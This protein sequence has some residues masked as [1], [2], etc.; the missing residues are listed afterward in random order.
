MSA[1]TDAPNATDPARAEPRARR[2]LARAAAG[3]AALLA[4]AYL[5]IAFYAAH[6]LTSPR[7]RDG[8][9]DARAIDPAA[10]DW[11][12]TAEDGLTLRGW[13][14]PTPAH[15]RLAIFVHGLWDRWD[16]IAPQA[17]DLHRRGFDVLA[18]DLRGHGRSDRDRLSMG[19]RERRDVR[20]AL[21]WAKEEGFTPDR[22]GWVGYSLGGAIVVMEAA[23]NPEIRVG[24]VDSPFGDLPEVLDAQLARHSGLPGFFNPAILLAARVAFDVPVGDLVPIRAAARWGDRPLLVI[25]GTADHLVPPDQSRRLAGAAGPSAEL[26]IVPGVRHIEAHKADPSG[27]TD[28]LAAFLDAHLAP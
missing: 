18:F 28:R 11:T 7:H 13:Y 9:A 21:R 1:S 24:V 16:V 25:H 14:F 4:T 19:H 10:V 5:G 22:I 12:A 27:Y 26:V 6:K 17:A 2:R 3:L 8:R 15:R 23:E 20:A